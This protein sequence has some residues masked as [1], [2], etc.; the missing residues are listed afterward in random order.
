MMLG[1]KHSLSAAISRWISPM[2][3]SLQWTWQG[4]AD[5]RLGAGWTQHVS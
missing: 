1:L 3:S 5:G 2:S 4:N